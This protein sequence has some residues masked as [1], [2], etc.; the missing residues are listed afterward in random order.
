M[1][2]HERFVPPLQIIQRYHTA[3][4]NRRGTNV[5]GVRQAKMKHTSLTKARKLL[6][7]APPAEPGHIIL[8]HETIQK[9]FDENNNCINEG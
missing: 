4:G 6:E 5:Q 8:S 9:W 3:R 1:K 7:S 2:N